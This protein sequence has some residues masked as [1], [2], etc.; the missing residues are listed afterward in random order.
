M[1]VGTI[2]N[3]MILFVCC[4]CLCG[5]ACVGN[6]TVALINGCHGMRE[7]K[8]GITNILHTHD[9][10]HTI[11]DKFGRRTCYYTW[12]D[13]RRR[14]KIKQCD[15]NLNHFV[16]HRDER[17]HIYTITHYTHTHMCWARLDKSGLNF[18]FR[19]FLRM[20]NDWVCHFTVLW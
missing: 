14:Y 7:K 11:C 18:K 10:P 19:L 1:S 17:T 20:K 5:S 13:N 8:Q 15:L 16:T 6:L 12:N 3:N 9:H 4:H 2:D